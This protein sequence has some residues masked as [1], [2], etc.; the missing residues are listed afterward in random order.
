MKIPFLPLIIGLSILPACGSQDTKQAEPGSKDDLGTATVFIR[1]ALDD[2]FDEAR[3][4]LL[5]DSL[6]VNLLDVEQRFFDRQDSATKAGYH[7]SSIRVH[8]LKKLNDSVTVLIYSNSFMN[9]HDSLKILRQ[10][11]QWLVDLKYHYPKNFDTSSVKMP[12]R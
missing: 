12:Q 3:K 4:Y 6:N 2:N 10:H 7:L 1:S 9:I 11:G 8:D 5:P